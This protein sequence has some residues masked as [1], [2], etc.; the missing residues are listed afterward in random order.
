MKNPIPFRGIDI[1]TQI[2]HMKKSFP[3]LTYSRSHSEQHWIGDLKPSKYS[4]SYTIKI[5]YRGNFAPKAFV[6]NPILRQDRPHKYPDGSLCLYFP[7]EQKWKAEWLIAV[8]F[9]PW[10]CEYLYFY[11]CW[12]ETGVWYGEEAPHK[13]AKIPE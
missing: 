8:K 6:L 13:G 2:M 12:L 5:K 11:E 4:D 10:I 1:G 9:V 7:R 3:S